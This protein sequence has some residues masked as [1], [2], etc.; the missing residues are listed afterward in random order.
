[1]N[2]KHLTIRAAQCNLLAT[3]ST[4]PRRQVGALIVDPK[5]NVVVSE[6]YN[7]PPRGAKGS[8]CGGSVCERARR[9]IQSGQRND[10]GCHHAEMN[11]T[12]NAARTGTSTLGCWMLVNCDPCLM[13]AK[14]I[15][16]VGIARVY[17][18]L[19]T[20]GPH[21]EGLAYLRDNGVELFP[22]EH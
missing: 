20:D 21:A 16:H 2:V 17:S 5:S 9:G 8:M 10:I 6:G 14:N 13:C 7:G 19:D 18:P 1:M 11:A 4:C 22:I 15:H 12:A 3:A